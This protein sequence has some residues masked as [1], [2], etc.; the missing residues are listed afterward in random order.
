MSGST[1]AA[2]TMTKTASQALTI[3]TTAAAALGPSGIP[4]A[5]FLGTANA[6]LIVFSPE[7]EDRAALTQDDLQRAVDTI[8]SHVTDEAYRQDARRAGVAINKA[9]GFFYNINRR[10]AGGEDFSE[11]DL[12][13]IHDQILDALGTNSDLGGALQAL[14]N[15]DVGKFALN[16]YAL[17]CVL[18]VKFRFWDICMQANRGERIEPVQFRL[19][20]EE[21]REDALAIDKVLHEVDLFIPTKALELSGNKPENIIS[22]IMKL[23]NEYYGGIGGLQ[24]VRDIRTELT[25]ISNYASLRADRIEK[26]A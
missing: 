9:F 6:L 12:G 2:E 23:K 11:A 18:R 3:A 4:L 20:Q 5:S 22:N 10:A 8:N 21:A 24:A 19:I 15:P 7:Y 14:R 16:E 13:E 17:G 26:A 25:M 1:D